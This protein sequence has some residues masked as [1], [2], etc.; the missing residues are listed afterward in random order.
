MTKDKEINQEGREF[1]KNHQIRSKDKEIEQLESDLRHLKDAPKESLGCYFPYTIK[2][3]SEQLIAYGY[4][5]SPQSPAIV[6]PEKKDNPY[7]KRL[8]QSMDGNDHY[9]DGKIEGWNACLEECRKAVESRE[10]CDTTSTKRLSKNACKGCK[11][12]AD[13]LG[14]CETFCQGANERCAYCDHDL[15]CHPISWHLTE[16]EAPPSGLVPIDDSIKDAI[17]NLT[18]HSWSS[19]DFVQNDIKVC[20]LSTALSWLSKVSRS[21]TPK[22][23]VAFPISE[24]EIDKEL[25]HCLTTNKYFEGTMFQTLIREYPGITT[26][27]AKSIKNLLKGVK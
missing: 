25:A 11:T 23:L 16:I 8:G 10:V 17:S 2:E 22:G 14:P 24:E 15:K 3:I 4:S 20:S 13:N 6:W 26:V 19:K 5:R 7:E 12:Y 21:G 9:E 27:L 1:I 18:E